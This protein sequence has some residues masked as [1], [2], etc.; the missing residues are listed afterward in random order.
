MLQQRWLIS[1][2]IPDTIRLHQF[3]IHGMVSTD[4]TLFYH[5]LGALIIFHVV[6]GGAN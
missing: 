2:L 1:Q 3:I 6:Q 4:K 5:F